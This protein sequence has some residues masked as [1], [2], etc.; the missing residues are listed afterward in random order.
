M[1][2]ELQLRIKEIL[3][4]LFRHLN[5]WF[6]FSKLY[7]F[8]IYPVK[9]VHK[10][11]REGTRSKKVNALFLRKKNVPVFLERILRRTGQSLLE[12]VPIFLERFFFLK[13]WHLLFWNKFLS[14]RFW[15]TLLT[16]QSWHLLRLDNFSSA[17]RRAL[18]D[19]VLHLFVA[20]TV[21]KIIFFWDQDC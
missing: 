16:R 1:W 17:T 4:E 2:L 10:K 20:Q 6:F 3:F 12:R 14:V 11:E 19:G 8:R 9:N 5:I 13:K 7:W 21:L 18:S 15:W